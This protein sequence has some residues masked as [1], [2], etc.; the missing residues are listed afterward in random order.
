M[1]IEKHPKK[2]KPVKKVSAEKKAEKQ[3][4]W[5]TSYIIL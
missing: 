2:D 4:V 1:D 5:A 3:K